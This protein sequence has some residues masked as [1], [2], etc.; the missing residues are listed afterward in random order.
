[1]LCL[2]EVTFGWDYFG[3]PN[4]CSENKVDDHSMAGN[5][6]C[7]LLVHTSHS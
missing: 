4:L 6:P 5:V 1:M 3:A 7:V 2:N